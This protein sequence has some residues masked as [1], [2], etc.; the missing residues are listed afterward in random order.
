M[1][2]PDQGAAVR[3]LTVRAQFLACARGPACARGAVLVQALPQ[4]DR[5]GMA[6]GSMGVGFTATKR[7]GN[8]VVRNR[9]KR[10][11]REAARQLLPQHGRPGHD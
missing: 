10:C 11:P 2:G 5:D 4:P 6:P 1:Q 9:A 3:R 8:A 7:S